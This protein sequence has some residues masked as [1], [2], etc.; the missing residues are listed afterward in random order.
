MTF[1]TVMRIT[2]SKLQTRYIV[3]LITVEA[4]AYDASLKVREAVLVV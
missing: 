2:W 4:S 1:M 3:C